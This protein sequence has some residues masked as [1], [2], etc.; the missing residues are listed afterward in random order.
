MESFGKEADKGMEAVQGEDINGRV[1]GLGRGRESSH[2][3]PDGVQQALVLHPVS[4]NGR[5]PFPGEKVD[6]EEG[7]DLPKLSGLSCGTG[8]HQPSH[9]CPTF[10]PSP[11][12]A[13]PAPD[14]LT[15][16]SVPR[17]CG[18]DPRTSVP[19]G[20][21]RTGPP[22]CTP[23]NTGLQPGPQWG[24]PSGHC[25]LGHLSGRHEGLDRCLSVGWV[26]LCTY[27]PPPES[28]S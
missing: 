11:A 18:C 1:Y 25:G 26:G 12:S 23:P 4:D 16:C 14:S 8:C 3:G 13:P 20:C 6:S 10:K 9:W 24:G 27:N 2:C 19:G 28:P 17:P 21:D 22:G 7:K 15:A 5:A